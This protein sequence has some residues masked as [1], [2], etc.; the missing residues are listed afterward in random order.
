MKTTNL[1]QHSNLSNLDSILIFNALP[2]QISLII[3]HENVPCSAILEV[4]HEA[5]NIYV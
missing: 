3:F 1:D 4:A 5:H 2:I